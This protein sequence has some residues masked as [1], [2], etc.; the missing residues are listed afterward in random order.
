MNKLVISNLV[1]RP[2]R[3]LI[4]I[5]AIAI[6]VIL[7]LLIV[8]LSLGML[9]D[10]AERQKGVGA[11][12]MVL[13][14]NASQF[15]GMNG[16]PMPVKLADLLS[17]LPH[18]VAV[19]PVVSQVSTAGALE[20]ITGVDLDSYN[21]LGAPFRYLEGGPFDGPDEVL[22]DE[23]ISRQNNIHAGSTITVLNHQVKVAGVVAQGKGGRKFLPIATMQSWIGAQGKASAIYLKVDDPDKNTQTVVEEIHNYPGLQGYTARSMAEYLAMMTANNIPALNLFIKVVIGIAVI[24]GFIVIFQAMYTAVMERTREIGILKSLGATKFYIVRAILRETIL[25]SIVG[26]A[27][28]IGVSYAARAGL[29]ARFPLL[30]IQITTEWL[31]F[32][33][34]IALVG[35]L[36]G[37]LY[38]AFKAAQKDPIDALAYE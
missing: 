18:V 12:I 23:L 14:P 30:P 34:V 10:A 13:P 35:A 29:K 21:R 15:S 16:A 37:A 20:A 9:N 25:L 38:P 31:I 1:H 11:D 27:V 36:P 2:V 17:K 8:G 7:I 22:V 3:T 19:S 32:G 4:S 6:E 28:G 33:T 24:I 5:V 26:I